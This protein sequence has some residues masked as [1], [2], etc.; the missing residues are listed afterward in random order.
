VRC[1][2]VSIVALKDGQIEIVQAS[3]LGS[4]L[5]NLLLVLGMCFFFGGIWN[6]R[7]ADGRGAEQSFA[8]ATAQT[9]C[10]LMA[11]SSASLVIP[12]TVCITY[13]FYT[14]QSC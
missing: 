7:D 4:I 12:A 11:L 14:V 8:S 5:S 6:W 1:G 10:S 9:T 13:S 3:M 2:Q